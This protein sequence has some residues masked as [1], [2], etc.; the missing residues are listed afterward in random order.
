MNKKGED[1]EI[2]QCKAIIIKYGEFLREIFANLISI[3]SYPAITMMDIGNFTT[4]CKIV[5]GTFA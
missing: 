5:E 2:E 4:K 1:E 3:S